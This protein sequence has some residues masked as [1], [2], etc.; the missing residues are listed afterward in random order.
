MSSTS[1]LSNLSGRMQGQFLAIVVLPLAA[2]AGYLAV[3]AY[4]AAALIVASVTSVAAFETIAR[5]INIERVGA[6]QRQIVAV[7]VAANGLAI[8]LI[9][10][11]VLLAGDAAWETVLIGGAIG[12]FLAIDVIGLTW[13]ADDRPVLARGLLASLLII[14]V[15]AALLGL[16]Q[17]LGMGIGTVEATLAASGFLGLFLV[18]ALFIASEVR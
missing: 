4:A 9:G 11:A 12:A 18:Y 1:T 10:G 3:P 8:T 14:V 15:V 5:R 6:S 2:V 16:G 17:L 13:L 7:T